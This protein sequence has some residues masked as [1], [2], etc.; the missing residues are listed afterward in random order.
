M[1]LPTGLVTFLLTDVEDSTTAWRS[2]AVD[3]AT[4]MRRQREVID[5]AVEAHDGFRPVEQGEGD[6][7]VSVFGRPAFAVAAALAAQRALGEE[8]LPRVRMGI[9]T[10]ETELVDNRT[11]G[12]MGIIK[13]ARVRDL[14]QGGEILLSAATAAV[15]TDSLPDGSRLDPF[16]DIVLKGFDETEAVVRLAHD[17]LSSHRAKL[18]TVASGLPTFPTPLVGRK[19]EIVDVARLLDDSRL[20]TVTGSGGSGKTR[21]AHAVASAVGPSFESGVAWVDL[22]RAS[23]LDQVPSE[24][25]A[26]LGVAEPM[27]VDL[28]EV[29]VHHL[30]SRHVLVVFDN[31][32]HLLNAVADML[33]A[34]LSHE[35][36]SQL[37]VTTREPI[38]VAGETTWRIPS[39]SLP[40]RDSLSPTEMATHDAIALFVDRARAADPA[41]ELDDNTAKSVSRISRRLDGI[42]LA[43]ELAAA[44][45]RSMAVSD[46]AD[47][48]DDRFSL[49]T[50]GTRGSLERQR[51]LLASVQW[52][53]ALLNEEEQRLFRRLSVFAAPFTLSAAEAVGSDDELS[54]LDV[55]D[56]V[57]QLVDKS[58]VRHSNGRYSMLET[59]AAFASDRADDAGE[60]AMLRARHLE[61][62]LRRITGWGYPLAADAN[63]AM[64]DQ[65]I[66]AP[67]FLAAIDWS[68]GHNH[69]AIALLTCPL[70]TVWILHT[71]NVEALGLLARL[72]DHVEAGSAIWLQ[73][74]AQLTTPLSLAGNFEWIGPCQNG[75]ATSSDI[76][77]LVVARLRM[78]LAVPGAMIGDLDAFAELRAAGELSLAL[79]DSWAARQALVFEAILFSF[80]GEIRRTR[81]ALEALDQ[82]RSAQAGEWFGVHLARS[83]VAAADGDFAKADQLIRPYRYTGLA[84]ATDCLVALAYGDVELARGAEERASSMTFVGFQASFLPWAQAC[85]SLLEKDTEAARHALTALLEATG[86]PNSS[87]HG[88]ALSRL[89]EIVLVSDGAGPARAL[90]EEYEALI[91]PNTDQ[92]HLFHL[93]VV[94]SLIAI[95]D[96]DVARAILEARQA[97]VRAH[98]ADNMV[99]MMSGLRALALALEADDGDS[100]RIATL[101][102]AAD[103]FADATGCQWTG[104]VFEPA[105]E[106]LR[107]RVDEDAY[108]AGREMALRD[109]VM[110]VV[111]ED[112]TRERPSFGWESLTPG[113]GAS[114]CAGRRR[115]VEPTDSRGAPHRPLDCQD[116]PRPR[117]SEARY[118][119]PSRSR[120]VSGHS[121]GKYPEQFR[122]DAL[123]LVMTSGRSCAE[124]ARSLGV[125]EGTLWNWVRVA[126]AATERA[127][128]P[129]ALTESEREELRRLRK[130]NVELRTD[131]ETLRRAAAYFARETM[132]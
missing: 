27:G 107:S 89:V 88:H 21:L 39:L 16:G 108:T 5:A 128:D 121:L 116:P 127:R 2:S 43:L 111:E 61:W 15:V 28:T 56:L 41:F 66:E 109:A 80:F 51:T 1:A 31:C 14:A 60:L 79:G 3:A 74:V 118:R 7:T 59:L 76:D 130:E 106:Q 22:T 98:H 57:S 71:R 47:R 83:L 85:R 93:H 55:L 100:I 86:F 94:A 37:L 20:V 113:R 48:L 92:T 65:T 90:L 81:Q 33:N 82:Q 119:H 12:G 105:V 129:D 70:V 8:D 102:G 103:A 63:E 24:T 53:H 97:V 25:A 58:L 35:T 4:A 52:S 46:I 30:N 87:N 13:A 68:L 73:V 101:L 131:K 10:G 126:R 64:D 26:A 11:Y 110:K 67:E 69:E 36:A 112:T 34:L 124:V 44:R 114:G 95:A 49:L 72:N 122:R 120:C 45:C 104:P 9:H 32:E 75:L 132:R 40:G 84:T 6:S 23:A 91:P 18:R 125:A 19:A 29:I 96:D 38:G 50:T 117:L 123:E 77:P 54:P 42:P 17:D 99:F 115:K 78:G 62:C